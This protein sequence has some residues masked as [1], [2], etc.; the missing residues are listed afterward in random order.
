MNFTFDAAKPPTAA[1]PSVLNMADPTTVPTPI[2][3]WVINVP[4]QLTKNSGAEV[5]MAMN[6]AAATS[7]QQTNNTIHLQ[8]H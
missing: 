7:C 3:D 1:T 6:V 8:V 5:A 4:T 2:S